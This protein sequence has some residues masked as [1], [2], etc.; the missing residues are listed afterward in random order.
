MF[1]FEP[2]STKRSY[3]TT[4]CVFIVFLMFK[5]TQDVAARGVS[6]K[7]FERFVLARRFIICRFESG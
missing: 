3:L 7:D 2:T 5:I 4:K 1:L 6:V